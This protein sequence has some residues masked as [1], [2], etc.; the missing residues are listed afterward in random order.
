ML[1]IFSTQN[2]MNAKFP[3]TKTL[4]HSIFFLPSNP[5]GP[6]SGCW[7]IFWLNRVWLGKANQIKINKHFWHGNYWLSDEMGVGKVVVMFVCITQINRRWM[8]STKKS[9]ME[10]KPRS[11]INSSIWWFFFSE[12]SGH[13]QFMNSWW[14]KFIIYG[15]AKAAKKAVINKRNIIEWRAVN[16]ASL[17]SKR[18]PN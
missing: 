10:Q 9:W 18:V 16:T 13:M 17:P 1:R 8:I 6:F 14:K 7:S 5:C 3:S 4:F 12:F 15:E 11:I 2:F